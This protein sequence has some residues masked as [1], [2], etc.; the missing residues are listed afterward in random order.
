M[1]DGESIR[2]IKKQMRGELVTVKVAHPIAPV[3]IMVDEGLSSPPLLKPEET[4]VVPSNFDITIQCEVSTIS[5]PT[6]FVGVDLSDIKLDMDLLDK[7]VLLSP[8]VPCDIDSPK[9]L[10]KTLVNISDPTTTETP[11]VCSNTDPCIMEVRGGTST[12]RGYEV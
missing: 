2:E 8:P 1:T 6:A 3:V 7:T 10:F 12:C 5:E 4:V 9:D 11:D